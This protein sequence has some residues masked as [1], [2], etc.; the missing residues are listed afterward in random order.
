[1]IREDLIREEL[2][3]F[4]ERF[5]VKMEKLEPSAKFIDW[6]FNHYYVHEFCEHFYDSEP[7]FDDEEFKMYMDYEFKRG[8]A[9]L[10]NT[11]IFETILNINEI[12]EKREDFRYSEEE[13]SDEELERAYRHILQQIDDY[14]ETR[15]TI[16]N[17]TD[18]YAVGIWGMSQEA[19]DKY[20]RH[21]LKQIKRVGCSYNGRLFYANDGEY[22][23]MYYYGRDFCDRD[24]TWI[25]KR[26]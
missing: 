7:D 1:M 17:W 13:H 19:V 12:Q 4:D 10:E 20:A 22:G 11:A 5:G 26:R 9:C 24:F 3:D 16:N 8:R 2:K 21:R 25:F 6:I 15:L 23:Y 14:K 18:P